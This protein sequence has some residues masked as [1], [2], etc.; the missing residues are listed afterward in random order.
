MA[1]TCITKEI[2]EQ[3]KKAARA[4][5]INIEKMY[6]MTS[7]QRRKLFEDYVDKE[8]AQLVNGKFEEAMI[9][10][11]NLA[12]KKWAQETFNVREKKTG[13]Y[14]DVVKK[15]DDLNKLGVLTPENTDAY[16][17]DL[18]ATKLGA[19]VSGEEAKRISELSD[20]LQKEA[21]NKSEFGTPTIEYFKARRAM[22]DYLDSITPSSRLKVAT[23]IIARGTLLASFKSPLIN[24]ESN[25]VQGMMQALD[26]RL[27][28]R[29]LGGVNNKYSVDYIKFTNNV[30]AE[31]GYDVSRMT[32]LETEQKIRGE[33]IVTSQGPGT[34]RKIGRFYED[35]VFKK[36]QGAPDV[37]F[38]S[39]AFSDRANIE[40]T[41]MAQAQGLKG[42]ALQKK[43]LEIYKDATAIE[44]KTEEG[45]AVRKSAI[46]DALYTTY[47]NKST[48]STLALGIRK[49]F[50]IAS[51]D[52]RVGDQIMPFVKTPANVI[53]AGIDSSGVLVPADAAIRIA[54]AIKGI[55]EG[56][57]V[58]Q[59]FGDS[60]AGFGD[61]IIRAGLGLTFAFLLSNLFKPEDFIGEYPT[62]EKER[63]LLLSRNAATNS[64]RIGNK[65]VSLDYFGPL[66]GP[67]VGMLYG[68]KYGSD[69]PNTIWEYYK[70][71]GKQSAK[72]PGFDEF[73]N[74]IDSL[75]SAAPGARKSVQ[76]EIADIVNFSISFIRARTIPALVS[77]IAKGTDTSERIAASKDA[78]SQFKAGIPGLRQTLPEKK[79][80]F[81]NTVKTEGLISVLLAG[82]RVKTAKD[83]KV[84]SEMTRLADRGYM[85]SITDVEKTSSKAQELKTKIGDTKFAQFKQEYSVNLKNRI[86]QVIDREAYINLAIEDKMNLINKVKDYQLD[87]SLRK[88]G[89]IQ[90]KAKKSMLNKKFPGLFPKIK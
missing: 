27:K 26:R 11:D 58:S 5:K 48:Y 86:A 46:A 14:N 89:Y 20:T 4:G 42:E 16:L 23:S 25:S 17:E 40:T 12:L 81:G 75:K 67:L 69:L 15:I 90:P 21:P 10:T 24:I 45:Q 74:L 6:E 84:I 77:D 32:T 79:D 19:T 83:D 88:Y 44:P 60:F 63:Q 13:P 82:A 87:I 47:T 30:F 39:I 38:S 3:L 80:V 54:K 35:L 78:T 18:V 76:D 33:D 36:M 61:T 8:T 71:V 2:A 85:P 68:K 65:W 49:L 41:K 57:T 64:L 43:A 72:L 66:G 29:S 28:N 59:A 70:G 51:G 62:T 9:S 7:E 50:N 53:G 31:T 52:L 55:H 56:E 34:I 1:I 22:E 73:Y 37:A